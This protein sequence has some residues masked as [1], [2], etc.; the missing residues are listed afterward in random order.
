VLPIVAEV[1]L[2]LGHGVVQGK[3]RRDLCGPTGRIVAVLVQ[4]VDAEDRLFRTCRAS[5][6]RLSSS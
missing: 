3:H 2:I 6:A 5:I 4:I 1:V